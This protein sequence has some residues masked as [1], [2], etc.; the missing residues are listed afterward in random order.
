MSGMASLVVRL[1]PAPLAEAVAAICGLNKRRSV[2]T[3]CG[4]FWLNPVSNLGRHLIGGEYEPQMVAVLRRY[5]QTGSVFVD[6]GANEGFFSVIASQIVG[7]SGAV[8]AV[9]PQSRLQNVIQ[10]NLSLNTCYNVRLV[11]AVLSSQTE[12]ARLQLST[13]MNTGG[14]SL[15]DNTRYPRPSEEVR[16]F[17]LAEF[18]SRTGTPRCDLM[19]VDIEGAEYDVFMNAQAILKSGVIRNIALEI[20]N[21]V[22]ERRGLSGMDLHQT[23]L[24]CGYTLCKELGPWVYRF[25]AGL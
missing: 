9:E 4:V 16:S 21:S 2:Q 18:L 23:I 24:D 20:H 17:T 22:L 10:T 8:I 15:Y 12:M 19:K 5:L 11:R 14:S 3:E 25:G 1:R 7:P 6:L 13:E